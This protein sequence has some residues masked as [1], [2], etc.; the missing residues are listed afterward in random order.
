MA[1]WWQSKQPPSPS[2]TDGEGPGVGHNHPQRSILPRQRVG[3]CHRVA[4]L[5]LPLLEPAIQIEDGVRAS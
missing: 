5:L 3:Q 1:A 4:R 2:F